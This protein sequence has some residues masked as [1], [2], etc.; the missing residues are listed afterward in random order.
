VGALPN[1]KKDCDD[2]GMAAFKDSSLHNVTTGSRAHF[3]NFCFFFDIC[4]IDNGNDNDKIKKFFEITSTVAR[5]EKDNESKLKNGVKG[6]TNTECNL[7][8]LPKFHR[9]TG[10]QSL[11]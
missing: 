6:S 8:T 3:S 5:K 10:S 7:S 9:H 11:P 1:T 2:P 4:V